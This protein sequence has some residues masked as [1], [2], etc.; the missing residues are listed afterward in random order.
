MHNCIYHHT[1]VRHPLARRKSWQIS[2]ILD[3]T[4]T[5]V[6][7]ARGYRGGAGQVERVL[8]VEDAQVVTVAVA[9]GMAVQVV[10]V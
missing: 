8:A 10:V 6:A 4:S 5:I 3:G 9:A 1:M 2:S 7:D